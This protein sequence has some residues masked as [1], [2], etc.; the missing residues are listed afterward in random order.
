MINKI[1]LYLADEDTLYLERLSMYLLSKRNMFQ[2]HTFSDCKKLECAIEESKTRIDILAVS[3]QFQN[4]VAERIAAKVKVL[5]CDQLDTGV[6]NGWL[7]INKFQKTDHLVAQLLQAYE[8]ETGQLKMHIQGKGSCQIWGV[9]S[10]IGGSGKTA[11]S[12]LLSRAAIKAGFKVFYCNMEHI[13]SFQRKGG[14]GSSLSNVLLALQTKGSNL[15]L[16]ININSVID[17]RSGISMFA[18]P[19]STL[20]W[21][22]VNAEDVR[23]LLSALSNTGIADIIVLDFDSELNADKVTYLQC[24]DHILMAVQK[25]DAAEKKLQVFRRELE[26]RAA[27]FSAMSE[28]IRYVEN[29]AQQV[30]D[31]GIPF[32]AVFASLEQCASSAP[33]PPILLQIAKEWA[34][35]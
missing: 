22:E 19:E 6:E 32:D 8:K 30:T 1:E 10:P 23:R 11:V 4:K 9:Y 33:I 20:E 7:H 25:G 31:A 29:K 35:R 13:C 24:C 3:E 2:L 18:G 16:Q 17:D 14:Q 15:E 26:L 5:L 21:N 27:E 34:R 28:R 12:L